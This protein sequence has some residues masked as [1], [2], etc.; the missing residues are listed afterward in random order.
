MLRILSLVLLI[1]FLPGFAQAQRAPRGCFSAAEEKA[2]QIVRLGLRLREGARGCDGQPWNMHTQSLWDDIDQRF[3]ARFAAQT[4]ARKT[5]FQR[6]FS[7]DADNRLEAWNGRIVF[8][9]RNYP[10]SEVYCSGIKDMLEQVQ[11]KGWAIVMRNATK[12]ADEVRMDYRLCG[13]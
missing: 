13:K 10:L 7:D 9:F 3:G 4:N 1:S 5:A 6:E 12:G 8:Y 11:K 2:E